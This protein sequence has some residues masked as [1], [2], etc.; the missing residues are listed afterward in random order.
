MRTALLAAASYSSGNTFQRHHSVGC[1]AVVNATQ[2]HKKHSRCSPPHFMFKKGTARQKWI[3]AISLH[4]EIKF[5]D[6]FQVC[7]R[8]FNAADINKTIGLLKLN[9]VPVH[10]P[11]PAT[12]PRP[13]NEQRG[14]TLSVSMPENMYI[15][16]VSLSI[17]VNRRNTQKKRHRKR[18]MAVKTSS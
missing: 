11:A 6:Q 4:Q 7:A 10:F 2:F 3:A 14:K 1:R 5:S 18:M 9:A 12:E 17:S 15:F 8:H 16:E 13:A